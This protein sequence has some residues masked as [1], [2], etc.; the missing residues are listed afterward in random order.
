MAERIPPGSTGTRLPDFAPYYELTQA[1][2]DYLWHGPRDK[3]CID[4]FFKMLEENQY[5]IQYRVMLA[6]YRGKTVCHECKGSRLKKEALY[7]KVGGRHISELVEMPVQQLREFFRTCSWMRTMQPWPS[8]CSTKSITG[9]P[10]STM[11][12]WVI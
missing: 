11:S 2:K 5:K 12:D 7:V 8:A 6:R 4:S 10:S 1:Q 9:W 3:A